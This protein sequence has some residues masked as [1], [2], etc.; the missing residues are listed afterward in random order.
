M[1]RLIVLITACMFSFTVMA[2][3][4][5]DNKIQ[6]QNEPVKYCAKLRDGKIIVQQNKKDLVIDV[7]LANG[8]TIKMDGTI[9]KSDG[10]QLIL[11]NGECADNNGNV[12]NAK[13]T[14]KTKSETGET[15][16]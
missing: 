6:K 5:Q 15:P 10:S 13:A 2:Q 3:E 11:K 8:T 16:K 14:D 9:I 4:N 12:I 1:K 7:N